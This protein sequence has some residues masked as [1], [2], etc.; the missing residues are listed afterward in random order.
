MPAL[1][2]VIN[3]NIISGVFNVGDVGII[4]P[5]TFSTTYAGGGS[6]NSGN[7]LNIHN[8]SSVI[9][10]YGSEAYVQRSVDSSQTPVIQEEEQTS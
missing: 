6:F 9:N 10:V 3:V 2:G 7:T 1:V 4:S 8:E 5:S